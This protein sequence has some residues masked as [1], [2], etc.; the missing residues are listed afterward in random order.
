[1]ERVRFA[2]VGCGSVSHNRYFPSFGQMLRGQL[3]AVCDTDRVRAQTAAEPL[4]VHFFTDLAEMLAKADFD[5]LVNL[6]STQAHFPLSLRALQANKHVYTQK[7]IAITVAEAT[8]LIEEARRRSLV[9]VAEDH[10]PILPAYVLIR[11]LVRQGVI[12]KVCWIRSNRT[13]KSTATIDNWP[14]D[15][16]WYYQKGSGPLMDVGIEGLAALCGIMGPAK[17][18]TAMSG[19]NQPIVYVRG[20]PNKGKRIDVEADDVTLLILDFGESIFALLDTAWTVS[21]ATKVPQLEIYGCKGIISL[22]GDAR[23]DYPIGL[24]RDE[25]ELGIR[26]WTRVEPIP[27]P[28]PL[29]PIRAM[30]VAHAIDCILDGHPPVLSAELAR[31]CL[32]ICEKAFVA[33]RTG[34]TQTLETA[35]EPA[36]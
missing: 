30:G 1:M 5:L 35:F 2:V 28:T 22:G 12:G 11:N 7:P 26:G 19:I 34:I 6:T 16:S 33:A 17:R 15:P 18:V 21:H 24:Y 29:P 23:E 9:I 13:H 8:I 27:P 3:V 14:T 4:G 10:K 32:E 31:H 20:G 36:P 25:P